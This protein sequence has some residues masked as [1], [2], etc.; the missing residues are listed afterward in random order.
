MAKRFGYYD[1]WK[2]ATLDCPQCS[3]KGTFEEG[4]VEYHR[5]WMDT[6]CPTCDELLAIVSY[7]TEKETEGNSEFADHNRFLALW[8]ESKLKSDTEL[9]DLEGSSLVLTWDFEEHGSSSFTVI[10]YGEREIWREIAVYEGFE[11]FEELAMILIGKYGTRLADVEPTDASEYYLY[12]DVMRAPDVVETVRR[13]IKDSHGSYEDIQEGYYI[14]DTDYRN[15]P[16]NHEMMIK[17]HVAA[18][19]FMPWKENIA[20]IQRGDVIFLYQAGVGIVAV[21]V[22]NGKLQKRAYQ[23]NPEYENEEFSMPLTKFE[24][25]ESPM[26]AYEIKET[27]GVNYRFFSTLFSI[28]AETGRKLEKVL[29]SRKKK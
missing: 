10:R 2:S 1:N 12:G 21:G 18:A 13:T 5:E 23:G 6:S 19:F 3:W 9:P 8:K 7:P 28:D 24:L 14:V 27:C 25:I 16:K 20:R 22:A 17:E 29:R 11:R 15:D 26:S 4:H